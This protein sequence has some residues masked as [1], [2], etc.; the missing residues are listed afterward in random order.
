VTQLYPRALGSL[1]VDSFLAYNFSTRTTQ[2]TPLPYCLDWSLPRNPRC[3]CSKYLAMACRAVACLTVIALHRAHV[4]Q[5]VERAIISRVLPAPPQK[6]HKLV[7][8]STDAVTD[9]WRQLR[10]LISGHS[11]V[12][13]LAI[14]WRNAVWFLVAAEVPPS[15]S[16][17]VQLWGLPHGAYAHAHLYINITLFLRALR[18][19]RS[20]PQGRELIIIRNTVVPVVWKISCNST[21]QQHLKRLVVTVELRWRCLCPTRANWTRDRLLT[22]SNVSLSYSMLKVNQVK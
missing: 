8:Y 4:S 12:K 19:P 2:K 13:C 17:W 11:S 10:K 21:Y 14:G 18:W 16:S 1:F 5:Y 9:L 7:L 15:P 6:Y 20:W 3:F 22:P